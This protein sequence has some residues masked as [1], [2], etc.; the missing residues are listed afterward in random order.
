MVQRPG[1]EILLISVTTGRSG[2]SAPDQSVT[3]ARAHR[4]AAGRAPRAAASSA[5]RAIMRTTHPASGRYCRVIV[6]SAV[7]LSRGASSVRSA[8]AVSL[9]ARSSRASI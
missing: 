1:C 5:R 4:C 8:A 3:T 7:R 9:T 2:G 6:C